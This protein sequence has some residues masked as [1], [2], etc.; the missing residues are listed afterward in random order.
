MV[1]RIISGGQ[2]GSDRAALDFAI[3]AKIPHGGCVPRG[4][5]TE[6]GPLP[7]RYRV[8]EMPT[9]RY[10][11][12]T[13]QN[14]RV[15]DG[16]LVVSHGPLQGG[17]ALTFELAERHGKPVFRADMAKLSVPAAALGIRAW[18][19]E[20]AIGTLNVAGP[21]SSEDPRIYSVTL[22]VLASLFSR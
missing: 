4:R 22:S 19:Q 14:V 18:I 15:S 17:S 5:R 13:E 8:K 9:D 2:T 20:Y 6:E 16:T 12:R 3:R 21:R 11:A 10:E 7:A 1:T